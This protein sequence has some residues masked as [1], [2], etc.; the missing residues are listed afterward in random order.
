MLILFLRISGAVMSLV[1]LLLASVSVLHIT[2]LLPPILQNLLDAGVQYITVTWLAFTAAVIAFQSTV[3]LRKKY[4]KVAG[5]TV[6]ASA[7][8]SIAPTLA[9]TCLVIMSAPYMLQLETPKLCLVLLT[10]T[11]IFYACI[12]TLA[13]LVLERLRA[14]KFGRST[15]AAETVEVFS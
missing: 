11:L 10:D 13:F 9:C 6:L 4:R 5:A 8:F 2:E 1:G 3:A 14:R 7:V 12:A 15:K